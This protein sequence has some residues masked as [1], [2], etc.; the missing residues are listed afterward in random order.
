[1]KKFVIVGAIVMLALAAYTQL[2]IFTVA[3]I[4]AVPE[5]TTV[6]M[7]RLNS[8][9]FIDSADATCVRIQGKVDFLCR[10]AVIAA[11]L[12]GARIVTRLPYSEPLYLISTG[13]QQY[14]R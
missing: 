9:Q 6:V 5:G 8:T 7:L 14:D 13:N 4:E 3:P 11:V 10:G 2:T 1:M 12:N